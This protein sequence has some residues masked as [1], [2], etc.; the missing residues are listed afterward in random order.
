[1]VIIFQHAL[2]GGEYHIKELGYWIDGYD[3]HQNV[4]IEYDEYNHWHRKNR[5]KDENRRKEIIDFLK[6]KF[7]LITEGVGNTYGISEYIHKQKRLDC[8]SMG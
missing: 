1:M 2:N 6:C 4:V 3:K 7:I 8:S 5:I